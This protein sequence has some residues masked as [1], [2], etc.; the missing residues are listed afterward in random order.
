MIHEHEGDTMSPN[1]ESTKRARV[2]SHG[3]GFRKKS[4]WDCRFGHCW[5]RLDNG[6]TVCFECDVVHNEKK[7][8][9]DPYRYLDWVLS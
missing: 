1:I 9:L 5:E 2:L 4:G 8:G 7:H 6:V 3:K